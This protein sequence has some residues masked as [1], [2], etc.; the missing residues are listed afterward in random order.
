MEPKRKGG[1]TIEMPGVT[2]PDKLR[3]LTCLEDIDFR[4]TKRTM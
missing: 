2:W 4:V 1:N 3:N